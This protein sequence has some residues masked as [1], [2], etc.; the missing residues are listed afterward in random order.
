VT[1]TNAFI[2]S[3]ITGKVLPLNFSGN[4]GPISNATIPPQA[5]FILRALLEPMNSIGQ[6]IEVS[7]PDFRR[8]Y[9]SFTLGFESP[10]KNY[11][12]RFESHDTEKLL[13]T[14]QDA[15]SPQK[16]KPTVLFGGR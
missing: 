8:D 9:S 10:Q 5:D 15:L 4:A 13:N 1:P 14:L 11:S 3:N 16:Q 2:K 12:I 6:E 7:L